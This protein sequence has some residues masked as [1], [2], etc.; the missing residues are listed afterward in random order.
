LVRVMV[1]AETA[2]EADQVAQELVAVVRR[3]LSL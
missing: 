1:E 3:R 2:A